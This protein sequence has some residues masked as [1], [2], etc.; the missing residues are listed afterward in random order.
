MVAGNVFPITDDR[1][2]C[3]TGEVVNKAS[4]AI[5]LLVSLLALSAID[6]HRSHA[7]YPDLSRYTQFSVTFS[8]FMPCVQLNTLHGI[9]TS[10][11]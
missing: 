5:T 11:L 1:D 2:D 9:D 10:A 4:G 6:Y 8:Y 7:N 3:V